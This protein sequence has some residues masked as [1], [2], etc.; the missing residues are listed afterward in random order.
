MSYVRRD[1]QTKKDFI[2]SVKAGVRLE[3]YNPSGMF[4][5]PTD[6]L[7]VIEGPHYPRCHKWYA[8]VRVKDGVVISAK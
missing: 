2:E 8:T 4:P 3:T 6:G 1:F 5:A 7:D